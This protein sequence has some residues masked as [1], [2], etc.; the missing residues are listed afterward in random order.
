MMG[1]SM[2]MKGE[3]ERHLEL[4]VKSASTGAVVSNVKPKITITDTT[5]MSMAGTKLAVVA[6]Q[7]VTKGA[8]DFH[9]GNN[10]SLKPGDTYKVSVVVN[11]EK[12]SFTFK[13]Q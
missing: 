11:G 12:A 13:A 9:Y 2:A 3:T 1:N 8:S 7:G 5:A 4:H 6:M 10:V